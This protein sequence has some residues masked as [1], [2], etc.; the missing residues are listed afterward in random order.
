MSFLKEYFNFNRGERRGVAILLSLIILCIIAIQFVDVFHRETIIDHEAFRNKV[1]AFYRQS[2]TDSEPLNHSLP[3]KKK[4]NQLFFFDPNKLANE[5]WVKLGL[6][7]KQAKVI[8]N[9]RQKG[10][11]FR[12]KDDLKK[13]YSISDEMFESFR[14]YIQ[15]DT[16]LFV[17][18]PKENQFTKNDNKEESRSCLIKLNDAD[19]VDLKKLYGIGSVLSLRIMKYRKKLGGFYKVEQLKEVYGLK[20]EV[21]LDNINCLTLDTSRI[22]RISINEAT[23]EELKNHPY[24][25]WNE[26]NSIVKIRQQLGNYK[27]IE[28]IKSS[29]LIDENLYRKIVHYL[30][31]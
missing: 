22:K 26:A 30:K 19:T 21:I 31:L 23:I 25:G 13:M 2:T 5:G 27:A 9:Y 24:I 16:F 8:I 28:G 10:G 4:Q 6:S 29:D 20:E 11:V 14:N 3:K 18:I 17:N 15:I 7:K 12:K 1:D